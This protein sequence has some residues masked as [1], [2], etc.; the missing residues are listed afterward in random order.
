MG[1]GGFPTEDSDWTLQYDAWSLEDEPRREGLCTLANGYMGVRGAQEQGSSASYPALYL[2]GCYDRS[3]TRV[4]GRQVEYEDMV[5]L[6]SPFDLRL[7]IED[8]PWLTLGRVELRDYRQRLDLRDGVLERRLRLCDAEGRETLLHTRRLV[9]MEQAHLCALQWRL[10]PL[11]WS[12]RLRLRSTLEGELRNRNVPGDFCGSHL[13]VIEAD[14]FPLDAD[15]GVQ[16]LLRTRQSRRLIAL[17]QRLWSDAASGASCIERDSAAVHQDLELAVRQGQPVRVEKVCAVYHSRDPATSEPAAA[18]RAAVRSAADFE[19]LHRRHALAWAQLWRRCDLSIDYPGGGQ[20]ALRLNLFHLLQSLSPNTID[21]DVGVTARGFHGEAYRGHVF[22]DELFVFPFLNLHFPEI[23]RAL[24]L[25]RYRRLPEARRRARA[26]GAEGALYPW[27]S[28][29]SGR[30]ET[31][32]YQ[33]NP[34]SGHW[35]PDQTCLQR[36]INAAIA[37]NVWHY[38]QATA[39]REFLERYGAEMILELARFW[40][41]YASRSLSGRYQFRAV[42]GPDE[43]HTRYPDAAAPGLDNNAYT[44][45]MAAWTLR[46]APRVL[47]ELPREERLAL[48]ERLELTAEDVAGWDQLWRRVEVPWLADGVIAQFEGW[49]ELQPPDWE[50]LRARH[51]DL[52]RLDRILEAEGDDINRYQAAKQADVLMLFYLFT[53]ADLRRLLAEMGYELDPAAVERTI[54]YYSRHTTHAS[55]LSR[56]VHAWVSARRDRPGAGRWFDQALHTDTGRSGAS[57]AHG[58]HLGAMA[59]SIDLVE[60][61]FL[62]VETEGGRLRFNPRLPLELEGVRT[63][64]RYR[65]SWLQVQASRDYLGLR[66]SPDSERPLTVLLHDHREQLRPGEHAEFLAQE[67]PQ[68]WHKL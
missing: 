12:G 1:Q 58:I 54:D 45:V 63:Q 20:L 53:A 21:L 50:R 28:G 68:R 62:G 49:G 27:R 7:A 61:G 59:G 35:V 11:N 44:N 2:A 23:T 10:T 32:A 26:L 48:L 66:L 51:D 14:G 25:Y 67:E 8:G 9:H 4:H 29:S 15:A 34:L 43:F 33:Y 18:A 42:V 38:Y 52:R 30:E 19:T 17:A 37:Y 46:C 5:R 40:A 55:T 16:L 57:T 13:E 56:V 31:P 39:D 6:P 36:H 41:S 22:W 47:A 65:G 24:L 60:R 64:L 3:S